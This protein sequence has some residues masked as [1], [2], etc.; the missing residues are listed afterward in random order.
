MKWPLLPSQ[1]DHL[2]LGRVGPFGMLPYRI[3]N[4]ARATHMYVIG[5][6]GQGKSK[7][8]ESLLV[9]DIRAGRGCGLVDPHTDLARDTLAHLLS[10]GFFRDPA[11]FERVIYFDPTRTDCILPFNVLKAPVAPYALAQQV[12][13]AFRRTWP[14]SLDEAP[15]FANIALAALLVLIE[16]GGS[17]IDM[18]RLL[19]DR[20]WRDERLAR[21]ADPQVVAFFRERFDR[22]GREG[23]LMIESTLNKVA[24]F[25][26]NPYLRH[27]LGAA[28]NRL[29]FRR[30][31]DSGQVLLVD[32]GNCDGET[33]RLVG[34]LVVTGLEMAAL[35]RKDQP[36]ERR[37]FYLYLDE[38]QDFCANDG[39]AKTLAQILS[40][41]RKFGLH[42]HLAHQTLG[43]VQHRIASA[44]GNVGIKVVFSIDREDAEV[45]ARKL[46]TVD[47]DE[48]KHDAQTEVQH[49]LFSPLPEQWERAV[50]A[51]QELPPRAALV[52]RRGQPLARIQTEPIR[53]YGVGR[54]D[55]EKLITRLVRVHGIPSE[56]TPPARQ[57][58]PPPISRSVDWE[59]RADQTAVPNEAVTLEKGGLLFTRS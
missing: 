20:D 5:T 8:L 58:A 12:I 38:F 56:T 30:I 46:F 29:D 33:R 59:R 2:R 19:T 7:F 54:G 47:T 34:S 41:C 43:Q 4:H 24:A 21:V 32:L 15:Q 40:E 28:E 1:R 16:T 42:L 52:K 3:P 10:D 9:Q 18:A 22:W 23:P 11:S 37:P 6:T 44:L 39:A 14:K 27:L 17:L 13:E 50:A 26:F 25:A 48:V 57:D 49:P 36:G 55:I 31:M 53:P 35:S 51:I 45:L